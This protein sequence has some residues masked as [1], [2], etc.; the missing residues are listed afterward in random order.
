VVAIPADEKHPK[1]LFP[2]YAS[3]TKYQCQ[4]S[5]VLESLLACRTGLINGIKTWT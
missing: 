4:G 3:R 5:Q 2:S 1:E